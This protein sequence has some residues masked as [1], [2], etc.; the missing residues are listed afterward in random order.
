MDEGCIE[1]RQLVVKKYLSYE[2]CSGKYHIVSTADLNKP[3][4]EGVCTDVRY[5]M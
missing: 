5:N 4:L 3:N 1:V 2:T